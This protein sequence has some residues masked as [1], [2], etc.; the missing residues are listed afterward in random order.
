MK[1]E[2][3]TI[4]TIR[5]KNNALEMIDQ[6]LLPGKLKYIKCRTAGEVKD[7]IKKLKVR[8]APAIGIAGAYGVYL[9]VMGSRAKDAR[10]FLAHLKKAGRH[11]GGSR[12][13]ARNLFWG[14]ERVVKKV[15]QNMQ[16]PVGELKKIVL[17]EAHAILDED[18][19]ICRKIGKYGEA[20]IKNNSRVLTHCNAGALATADYGTALGVIIAARKKIRNVFVDETR[21][22]LQGARLTAW[23]LLRRGIEAT[24]ICDN[25]AGSI[26]AKGEVDAVI[27]GADRIAANGDAANKIGTYPLAVLARHHRIPFYVAAPVSTFDLTLPA[28]HAIPIEERDHAEVRVIHGKS[29]TVKGVGVRNPA[30]DVT[31]AGLITA[32]ITERGIIRSPDKRKILAVIGR[33]R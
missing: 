15:E 29:I 8:G 2:N 1:R 28:G 27:V 30:F 9:G 22:V 12:P 5:W 26:M 25:M 33:G 19:A 31:P 24:L 16:N 14:I 6:R 18:K 32:I 13:T 11:I 4:E 20:L 7:A 3:V 17:K 21:P 23:E 10:A